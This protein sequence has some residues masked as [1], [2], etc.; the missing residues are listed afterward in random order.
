MF[1]D[2]H[3][4]CVYD[5]RYVKPETNVGRLNWYLFSMSSSAFFDLIKMLNMPLLRHENKQVHKRCHLPL[6]PWFGE[7]VCSDAPEISLVRYV[8][9][10]AR[11]IVTLSSRTHKT[12]DLN[13]FLRASVTKFA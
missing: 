12:C 13:S 1:P 6:M 10:T 4:A 2:V 9:W 7:D 8:A 3:S 5:H 11:L